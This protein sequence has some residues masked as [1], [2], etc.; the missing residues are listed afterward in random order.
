MKVKNLLDAR[1]YVIN[2]EKDKD[3][4]NRFYSSFDSFNL[5]HPTR[6]IA[7]DANHPKNKAIVSKILNNGHT[8]IEYPTEAG[9]ALSHWSILSKALREN[10]E[11]GED[12]VV[13][14][15]DDPFPVLSECF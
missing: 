3:R 1:S 11:W 5:K 13:F 4:L 15:Y 6:L 12:D 9:C 7:A 8:Y 10:W 2:L 14:E